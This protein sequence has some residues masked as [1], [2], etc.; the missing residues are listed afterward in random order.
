[1]TECVL[2]G[3]CMHIWD[4]PYEYIRAGSDIPDDLTWNS[5]FPETKQKSI[6]DNLIQ[7][8]EKETKQFLTGEGVLTLVS[9]PYYM[10][11]EDQQ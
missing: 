5:G 6:K 2:G 3:A 10:D 11:W 9:L 4:I 8:I 7:V 1:M